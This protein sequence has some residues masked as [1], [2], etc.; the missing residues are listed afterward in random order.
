MPIDRGAIEIPT[1]R[2]GSGV[3]RISGVWVTARDNA[4][5]SEEKTSTR[6]IDVTTLWIS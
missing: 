6:S 3:L 2:L 1:R 4:E 5:Q